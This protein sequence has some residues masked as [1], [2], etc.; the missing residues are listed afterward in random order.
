MFYSQ[1]QYDEY[2]SEMDTNAAIVAHGSWLAASHEE[3][4]R[5][6]GRYAVCPLDCGASEAL[7]YEDEGSYDHGDVDFDPSF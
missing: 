6:H 7:M 2:Q 1:E 5:I 3:W 4:H